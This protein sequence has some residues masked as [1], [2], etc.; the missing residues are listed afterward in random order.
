MTLRSETLRTLDVPKC[1]KTAMMRTFQYTASLLWNSLP[2]TVKHT[3][4]VYLFRKAFRKFLIE[5]RDKI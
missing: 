1:N 3:T 5:N 4:S 2:Q